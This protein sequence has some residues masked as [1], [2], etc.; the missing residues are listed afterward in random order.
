MKPR[1]VNPITLKDDFC[2]I[3]PTKTRPN[4]TEI[5]WYVPRIHEEKYQFDG[6]LKETSDIPTRLY[7]GLKKWKASLFFWNSSFKTVEAFLA[8]ASKVAF[9]MLFIE[10]SIW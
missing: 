2:K 9:Q 7:L 10:D 8:L 3:S 5:Q 6:R 4:V 1:S